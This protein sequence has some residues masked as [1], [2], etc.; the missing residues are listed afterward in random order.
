MPGIVVEQSAV[1]DFYQDG[2]T[3]VGKKKIAAFVADK[4]LEFG[5][6]SCR[7]SACPKDG[8]SYDNPANPQVLLIESWECDGTFDKEFADV[9]QFSGLPAVIGNGKFEVFDGESSIFNDLSG[10]DLNFETG[11][12]V[13][14]FGEDVPL[15][16]VIDLGI[17]EEAC[18]C[19]S[20]NGEQC[21]PA[22]SDSDQAQQSHTGF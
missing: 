7:A 4:K 20:D 13:L 18:N 16:F 17:D 10:A 9:K 11:V 2:I 14:K 3:L 19:Y 5:K 6:C 21:S 15:N 1:F 22:E 8:I 12:P